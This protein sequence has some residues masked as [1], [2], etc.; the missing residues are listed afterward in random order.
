MQDQGQAA[1]STRLRTQIGKNRATYSML[2]EPLDREGTAM[3]S[4]R[5][6]ACAAEKERDETTSRARRHGRAATQMRRAVRGRGRGRI[7]EPARGVVVKS[8]G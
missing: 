1:Q 2:S 3:R 4:Q 5:G 8:L 7:E 6:R